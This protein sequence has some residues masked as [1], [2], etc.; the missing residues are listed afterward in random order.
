MTAGP[1]VSMMV[2]NP[3]GLLHSLKLE[4]EEEQLKLPNMGGF[5]VDVLV[6]NIVLPI[7]T[8][9]Y[10]NIY[11]LPKAMQEASHEN[12]CGNQSFFSQS[13]FVIALDLTN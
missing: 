12:T 4:L 3:D 8:Q 9:Y 1:Q 2:V 7:E 10:I 6:V 5:L 13:M 11:T